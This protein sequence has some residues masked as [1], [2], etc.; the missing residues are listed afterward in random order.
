MK[1]KNF[2]RWNVDNEYPHSLPK[3][4]SRKPDVIGECQ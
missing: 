4:G 1:F 3:F 2:E